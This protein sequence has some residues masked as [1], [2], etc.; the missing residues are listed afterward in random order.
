MVRHT[1][2]ACAI[3][4]LTTVATAAQTAHGAAPAPGARQ[5][6]APPRSA[7]PPA[8]AQPRTVAPPIVFPSPPAGGLTPPV[9]FRGNGATLQPRDLFRDGVRG[10]RRNFQ[11]FP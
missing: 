7:P 10:A 9:P 2:I 6:P 1:M 5:T 11:E 3:A 4:M 8:A